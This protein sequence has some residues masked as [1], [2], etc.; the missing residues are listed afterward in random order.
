MS[1]GR[2]KW[3]PEYEI[4]DQEGKVTSNTPLALYFG[5]YHNYNKSWEMSRIILFEYFVMLSTKMA[6]DFYR[7]Q[8][9]IEAETRLSAYHI[10]KEIAFLEKSGFIH[11]V[12]SSFGR[13]SYYVDKMAIVNRIDE[14]IEFEKIKEEGNREAYKRMVARSFAKY[15][16]IEDQIGWS[17]FQKELTG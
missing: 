8:H 9:I 13:Y 1:Y 3:Y 15:L 16:G 4:T 17:T 12:K 14:I 5:R 2:D 10:R 6:D 11:K 7:Q